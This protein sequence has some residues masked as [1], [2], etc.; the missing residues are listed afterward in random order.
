ME[1]FY[2]GW[3][4]VK[5][6][7]AADVKLPKEVFLPRP[8]DRQVCRFLEQRREFPIFDVIEALKPLAQKELIDTQ[9]EDVEVHI[10]NGTFTA[11]DAIIAPFS[12]ITH[13]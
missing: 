13:L 2:S 7:F 4:I 6:F 12:Y 5:Q 1:I 3:Q 8:A 9:T 10:E 11:T